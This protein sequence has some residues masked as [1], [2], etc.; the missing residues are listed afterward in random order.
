MPH[1]PNGKLRS[2]GLIFSMALLVALAA[3]WFSPLVGAQEATPTPTGELVVAP[4]TVEAG[5][6]TLAVAFHVTPRDLEVSIEY[7]DLFA[8]ED[9]SC[10]TASGGST[11]RSVAPTWIELTPARSE[12]A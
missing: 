5:E 2:A 10:D 1:A 6:A 9:E 8:P 12:R 3:V 7:P 4:Q 11:P